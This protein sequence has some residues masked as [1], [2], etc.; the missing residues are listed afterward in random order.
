MP[1]KKGS[2]KEVLSHNIGEM[3]KSYKKT[4]KIGNTTPK[5]MEHAQK[6]AAAAAYKNAGKSKKKKHKEKKFKSFVE[7]FATNDENKALVDN[8][9]KGFHICFESEFSGQ[10]NRLDLTQARQLAAEW[11]SGQWSPLYAFASTGKIEDEEHKKNLIREIDE[12]LIHSSEEEG[13]E[14]ELFAL[15]DFIQSMPISGAA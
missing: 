5:D 8:L 11:H 6:I 15:S 1:L 13:G 7:S 9:I 14:D 3:I 12:N 10:Q 4:G 2:G